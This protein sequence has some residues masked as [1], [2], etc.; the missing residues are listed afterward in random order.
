MPRPRSQ[1]GRL[2]PLPALLAAAAL[3]LCLLTAIA[4]G[5]PSAEAAG[6]VERSLN[7]LQK[8]HQISARRVRRALRVYRRART[9]SKRLNRPVRGKSRRARARRRAL[10]P[11]RQAMKAQIAQ[12][13]LIARRRQ[14]TRDRISPL[15]TTLENNTRW[16]KRQGPRP[17]GTDRRFKGSRITFQYFPGSG[18]QWHPQSNFSRLN[19]IWT[20]DTAV[21]RRAQRSYAKL[22]ASWGVRRNSALVW[23]Y[24]FDH[25]GSRAPW[26]SAISQG[27]AIQSISRVAKRMNNRSLM[28][29]ARLGSRSFRQDPP[30]GIR[31]QRDGGYHYLAYSGAPRLIILNQFLQGLIG[32]RAYGRNSGDKGAMA[33][34]EKGLVAARKEVPMFDTGSWSLYSLDGKKDSPG[35]HQ[36]TISFLDKLCDYTKEAVFCGTRDRFVRYAR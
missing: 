30:R 19:A 36:L 5:A 23:E 10:K 25:S 32:L 11:R 1:T 9:L 31:L 2:R 14:L 26:V 29:T 28:R 35:Y 7:T 27:T 24:Y 12:V 18:W 17:A 34:Y 16:F 8:R 6:P 20:V 22:L 4:V 13:S 15:F 21:S 3:T 33:L